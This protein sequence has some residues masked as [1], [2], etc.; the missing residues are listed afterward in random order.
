MAGY[1][2]FCSLSSTCIDYDLQCQADNRCNHGEDD[3]L[4]YHQRRHP[5]NHSCTGKNDYR[6]LNETCILNGRCNQQ[7]ECPHG[8]DEYWCA[9]AKSSPIEHMI[10]RIIKLEKTLSV[11]MIPIPFY[12]IETK[13]KE[14]HVQAKSKI[15]TR[16][17]S[18]HYRKS[19]HRL[20][21]NDRDRDYL[22]FVCGQNGLA[23]EHHHHQTVC[24]CPPNSYGDYCEYSTDRIT[25]LTHLNFTDYPIDQSTIFQIL[26]TFLYENRILH[27]HQF[28]V[29]PRLQTNPSDYIKEKVYFT[30]PRSEEFLKLK[31]IYRHGTQLYHIRFEVFDQNQAS[32]HLINVWDYPIYF[33]FLPSHR[34]AKILTLNSTQS[35]RCALCGQHGVC[36]QTMN[37]NSIHCHCDHG[38]YGNYCRYADLHQCENT[39]S[40]HSIC[41][42]N[43]RGLGK[44]YCL[45]LAG[46]YGS[47]CYFKYEQCT[48]DLNQNNGI[49][50]I[51]F[52]FD[53]RTQRKCRCRKGFQGD[54]CQRI[55]YNTHIRLKT[56]MSFKALVVQYY[57]LKDFTYDMFICEQ[58]LY[59]GNLPALIEFNHKQRIAPAIC[60][61]RVYRNRPSQLGD[62]F[63]G[64][65]RQN[66][67][68]INL[69]IQL[70]EQIRCPFWKD[71]LTNQTDEMALFYFHHLCR[72]SNRSFI[73]FH[74]EIHFCVCNDEQ[75]AVC[76]RFDL[77]SDLCTRC[78]SSGRCVQG[79]RNDPGD[80][81]CLCPHCRY[82]QL[83]QYSMELMSFT[84][85]SL[86]IRDIVNPLT[87]SKFIG[88][89]LSLMISI[90]LLGL[91][92]NFFSYIT[93][94]R[95]KPREYPVGYYL[96]INTIISQC[97]LFILLMKIIHIILSSTDFLY[98]N[99]FNL[100]LCKTISYLLSVL[101]R[102]NYWLTSWITLQRLG[103]VLSPQ[104]SLWKKKK[105]ALISSACTVVILFLM[106][107][108]E[109]LFYIILDDPDANSLRL[110]VTNYTSENWFNYNKITVLIHYLF[111]CLIQLVSITILILVISR[112]RTRALANDTYR[113]I[114]IRQIKANKESF[115]T[116]LIILLS[117]LP[118]AILAFSFACSELKESW[119]RY[120][121]LSAYIFSYTP[122]LLGFILFVLPS[123]LYTTEFY[124]TSIAKRLRSYLCF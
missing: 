121:L 47:N 33:D 69:T 90:F 83:C 63:L 70:D 96:L 30:Y 66:Q 8:E 15:S 26:M 113:N 1:N 109:L 44:P 95:P 52:I 61:I 7:I 93:F 56:S 46:Y 6:C 62:Y 13:P 60:L 55:E 23:V 77:N 64:Y 14:S 78:L 107:I 67:V 19:I 11:K 94:Q 16:E 84:L 91:V 36:Y 17:S 68:R 10:Y 114:L 48:T 28:Y 51:D 75:R 49:C 5:S 73:C 86:I 87:K 97:S 115:L 57:D 98:N 53:G 99:L 37:N 20:F 71:L 2:F 24:F 74:D 79:D 82:G 103:V 43:Q 54:Q 124:E 88:L 9:P 111:P 101:T 105:F 32:S 3:I 123:T 38:W 122:Q 31:R 116:P 108:H 4:C 12:P 22:P 120:G 34:L 72:Q 117:A 42:P 89:Y 65:T 119:K 27:I 25:V 40:N 45:C 92:N 76:F 81:I 18:E 41:R 102:I 21:Q 35:S 112:S 118:Q 58:Q 106:H 39:C 50:Y 110:C 85:D 100:V 104:N 29:Q 80:F 59:R